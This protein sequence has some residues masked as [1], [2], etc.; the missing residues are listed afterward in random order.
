MNK[1]I[2]IIEDDEFLR[3][4][5]AKRLEQDGLTVVVAIDGLTAVETALSE[6]PHLILLDLLLPGLD[7][8]GVLEKLRAS[9]SCKDTPILI[10]SCFV[11]D[12]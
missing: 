4:I 11:A 5:A 10:F 6:K 2:L 3:A 8:F 1:K 7:G 12:S 9:E